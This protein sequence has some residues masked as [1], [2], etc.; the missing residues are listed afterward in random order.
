MKVHF[1]IWD[2]IPALYIMP[3]TSTEQ[4]LIESLGSQSILSRI[5]P[6]SGSDALLASVV[7]P[8]RPETYLKISRGA[9]AETDKKS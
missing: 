4:G 6:S 9:D 8:Y 1:S 5:V 2:K 7:Y 3:E